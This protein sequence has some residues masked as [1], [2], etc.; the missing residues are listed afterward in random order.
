MARISRNGVNF[1]VK[2]KD[3]TEEVIAQAQEAVNRSLEIIG[4]KAESYTKALT[5]VKTGALRNSFTHSV[6]GATV[7]VG[8]NSSYA[9]YVE[10]GTGNLYSPPPEW[11]ESHAK[12]GRGLDHW[13]Y[14]G[15]DGQ[16]HMG[17]PRVG[18]HM[19]QKGMGDHLDE[20]KDVIKTELSR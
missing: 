7:S 12:R 14:M 11:I 16:F 5:P 6:G 15:D 2:I 3:N 17:Y 13:V 19:L 8:S 4:G 18:V 1:N 9:S 10:L 20:Y